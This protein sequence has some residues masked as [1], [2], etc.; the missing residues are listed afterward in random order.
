MLGAL[1]VGDD[2]LGWKLRRNSRFTDARILGS[3]RTT[4]DTDGY[5]ATGIRGWDEGAPVIMVLGD[6]FGLAA[7][8]NDEE[9]FPAQLARRCAAS[10]VPVNVVNAAVA[11]YNTVQATRAFEIASRRFG[12]ALV[13]AIL[14][15][16]GNDYAENVVAD[17]RWPLRAPILVRRG[18]E[19]IEWTPPLLLADDQRLADIR[20]SAMCSASEV[21]FALGSLV[22]HHAA[23]WA[24]RVEAPSQLRSRR[25]TDAELSAWYA[26]SLR[27]DYARSAMREMLDRLQRTADRAGAWLLV[28]PSRLV[29]PD[30]HEADGPDANLL[31]A[32]DCAAAGVEYRSIAYPGE[33]SEI[34]ARYVNGGLEG[35]WNAKATAFVADVVAPIVLQR[36]RAETNRST[37]DRREP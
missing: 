11:G 7:Q 8:V 16:C 35:H 17:M 21:H 18:E 13:G 27:A 10:G 4:T 30:A 5:R 20:V 22:A 15:G 12:S 26:W 32:Q 37:A 9:T 34:M 28:I 29:P 2:V 24:T 6:S 31:L 25:M 1:A 23:R 3:P 14:V 36:L 33:A 19:W